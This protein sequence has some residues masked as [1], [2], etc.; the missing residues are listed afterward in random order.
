MAAMIANKA[1][2]FDSTPW[3]PAERLG[4]F[5]VDALLR[6]RLIG[7]GLITLRMRAVC[8]ERFGLRLVEQWTG[9]L[10]AAPLLAHEVFLPAVGRT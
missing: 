6:S 5:S 9:L 4:Q 8:G 3:L 10:S 2:A 1:Y 7:K